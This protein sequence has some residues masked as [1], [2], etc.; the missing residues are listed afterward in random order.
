[1][2][3]EVARLEKARLETVRPAK[4]HPETLPGA[5]VRARVLQ[6]KVARA[7]GLQVHQKNLIA[8]HRQLNLT[9]NSSQIIF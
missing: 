8:A 1:M 6:K 2:S 7:L 3:M 4:A 9:N 5:T